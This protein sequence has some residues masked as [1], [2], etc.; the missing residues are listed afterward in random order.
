VN[1]ITITGMSMQNPSVT[2][3]GNSILAYFTADVG[4]INLVG[5]CLV[6]TNRGTLAAWLPRLDTG[7]DHTLRR[8]TITHEPTRNSLLQHAVQMYRRMGGKH[9]DKSNGDWGTD[10]EPGNPIT[11]G[12]FIPRNK[13]DTNYDGWPLER[14]LTNE[15]AEA[16]TRIARRPRAIDLPPLPPSLVRVPVTPRRDEGE[17]A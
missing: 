5:C 6:R 8:V 17:E 9:V 7:H 3:R 1:D 14:D 16:N 12:E 11:E 10:L 15:E 13:G 4:P 2:P